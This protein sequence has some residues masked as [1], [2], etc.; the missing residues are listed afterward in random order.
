MSGIAE[1]N[2]RHHVL[3]EKQTVEGPREKDRKTRT[4][5][6]KADEKL[7][8]L[9]EILLVK[10]KRPDKNVHSAAASVRLK[11]LPA[12][13]H[14]VTRLYKIQIKREITAVDS[15]MIQPCCHGTSAQF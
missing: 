11:P 8:E 7:R 4:G 2:E 10:K 1:H 9:G 6:N 14:H 5:V 15:S 12:T 3:G 13:H